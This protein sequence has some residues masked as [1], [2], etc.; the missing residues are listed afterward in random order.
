MLRID[1]LDHRSGDVELMEAE[2][3]SSLRRNSP[4]PEGTGYKWGRFHSRKILSLEECL[5]PVS[6]SH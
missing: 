2:H 3:T 1:W 6:E 5:E 4:E